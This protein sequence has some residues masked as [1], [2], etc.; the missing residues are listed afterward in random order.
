[1]V[2]SSPGELTFE[3]LQ[4][5]FPQRIIYRVDGR[6]LHARIEGTK[7]GK[8]RGVDFPYTRTKCD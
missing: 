4:H 2:K 8:T 3:N 7:D 6:K 5:D 1:L